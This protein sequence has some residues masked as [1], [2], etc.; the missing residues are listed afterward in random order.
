MDLGYVTEEQVI[1]FI[2]I[3]ILVD[4]L[5]SKVL[6]DYLLTLEL[7]SVISRAVSSTG[8]AV[9]SDEV[10][11]AVDALPVDEVWGHKYLV[12]KLFIN[13]LEILDEIKN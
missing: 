1:L 12:S 13:V 3:G 8:E 11:T 6:K 5:L 10:F 9:G 4:A 7:V 2:I